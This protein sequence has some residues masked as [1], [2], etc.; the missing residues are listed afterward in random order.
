[1][2]Y[3]LELCQL[4]IPIGA[5]AVLKGLTLTLSDA[6]LLLKK[7]ARQKARKIQA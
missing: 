2:L 4:L 7:R 3:V 1:M 5:T 6:Q